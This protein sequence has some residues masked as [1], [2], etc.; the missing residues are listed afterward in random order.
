MKSWCC[1]LGVVLMAL[2]NTAI[3]G[4]LA[5]NA[6]QPTGC[7]S[8]PS[9]PVVDGS[10]VEAFNKSVVDINNWQQQAKA[11]FECLIKEANTDNNTIAESAN[12]EQAVFQQDVEKTRIAAESAKNKLD[13]H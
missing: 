7:G 8:K 6:W 10:S 3:A 13:K 4:S 1:I 2:E 5:N 11:Y 9:V 12:H